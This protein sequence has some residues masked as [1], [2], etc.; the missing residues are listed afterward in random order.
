MQ[1]LE[2]TL[3]ICGNGPE[4]DNQSCEIEAIGHSMQKTV[5][6]SRIY[7]T[8]KEYIL[9]N[10]DIFSENTELCAQSI[11][12]LLK[13]GKE[14]DEKANSTALYDV[15]LAQTLNIIVLSPVGNAMVN[16]AAENGWHIE[17]DDLNGEH[18]MLDI[19]NRIIVLEHHGFSAE[20]LMRSNY[21]ANIVLTNLV[22]A[23]RDVWHEKRH[24]GFDHLFAPE[25]ILMLERVRN[26]DCDV[27]CILVAW[28]LRS[29]G[30]TDIWRHTIG[31]S[32]GDLAV[33]YS[34][35]LERDPASQFNG[36]ALK[37]AFVHW[38][39]SLDRIK[40]CDHQTL[41]YMDDV[42]A[43]SEVQNP[44]GDKVPTHIAI[45]LLSCMPDKT[46]YLQ[47]FGREILMDP[48]YSGLSDA[49]NQAHLMHILHDL[50][51]T[52]VN[53]VAFRSA[54]LA[55]RIF[56]FEPYDEPA[57]NGVLEDF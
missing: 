10:N 40:A 47:G 51:A 24:G 5:I 12:N 21:F 39:Q 18:Y 30:H 14:T 1:L 26:A 36:K 8:R 42:L 57:N 27:M 43:A 38:Y 4:N 41:E 25:G 20:G 55:A 52:I 11:K 49:V 16:D 53:N 22:K 17:F 7:N 3:F 32:L 48:L 45:E 15:F 29:E 6:K 35:H 9:T 2:K 50:E 28:E 44:F 23:L 13:I 54:E 31:S 34:Y 56:P 46:A 33:A 19:E 37:S